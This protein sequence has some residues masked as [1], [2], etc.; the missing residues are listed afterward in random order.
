MDRLTYLDN[1]GSTVTNNFASFL[2]ENT[3]ENMRSMP[4]ERLEWRTVADKNNSSGVKN[5]SSVKINVPETNSCNTVQPGM[6]LQIHTINFGFI[7][8]L[9]IPTELNAVRIGE[10]HFRRKYDG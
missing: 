5:S 7:F 1:Q 3:V 9:K 6:S 2:S 8:L 4:L 10:H